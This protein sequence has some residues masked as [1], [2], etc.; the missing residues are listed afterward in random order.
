VS[1][2]DP[3]AIGRAEGVD[4]WWKDFETGGEDWLTLEG[5]SV[6]WN[7]ANARRIS[8]LACRPMLMQCWMGNMLLYREVLADVS[9]VTLGE[10]RLPTWSLVVC[11]SLGLLT[12][13]DPT[14]HGRCVPFQLIQQQQR[15]YSTRGSVYPT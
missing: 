4:S 14:P 5:V 10:R 8:G 12:K 11:M 2:D 9:H 15:D 1:S 7:S 6:S 3:N 13:Q